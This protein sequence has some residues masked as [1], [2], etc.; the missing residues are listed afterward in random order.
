MVRK[1]AYLDLDAVAYTGASTAQKLAYQYHMKDG[2]KSTEVFKTAVLAKTW[3]EGEVAFGM[4]EEDE[5]ERETI[6]QH[7]PLSVAIKSLEKELKSWQDSVKKLWDKDCEFVGWLT[8]SGRKDKDADGLEHRYQHNRYIDKKNWT[9][10]PKPVHLAACREYMINTYSWIKMSPPGIEADAVVVGLGERRGENACIGFKDKDLK[11]TM[12]VNLIDMNGNPR[13]RKLEKTTTLGKLELLSSVR[14]VK[15][16][17]GTG[18]KIMC[19]QVAAGDSADG[20]KGIKGFAAV[21]GF[22]LFNPIESVEGCCKALVDLYTSRFP[23]GIKYTS[24]NGK[25]IELTAMQLL[26]QH[27]RLAYHERSSR[28]LLTPIERYLKGDNPLYKH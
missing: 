27:M 13:D 21:A 16:V 19:Y 11:Q 5:W 28:D 17:E 26:T 25:E 6:T 3:F 4:I 15:S 24:W 14:E 23:E 1:V 2:T 12:N 10:K 9:A 20:Y 22:N 7:Q 8:S 18:F